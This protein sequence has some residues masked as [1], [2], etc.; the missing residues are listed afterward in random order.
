MKD[1]FLELTNMVVHENVHGL[2]IEIITSYSY[3][4]G[5]VWFECPSGDRVFLTM[6]DFSVHHADE[7]SYGFFDLSVNSHEVM[8]GIRDAGQDYTLGMWSARTWGNGGEE[9]RCVLMLVIHVLADAN[10]SAERHV[11]PIGLFEQTPPDLEEL[12]R[13]SRAVLLG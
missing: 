11:F 1:L 2:P 6:D 12:L 5:E 3:A 8:E 4:N 10:E 9:D 13:A 7:S